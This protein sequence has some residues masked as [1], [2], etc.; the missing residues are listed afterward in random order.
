MKVHRLLFSSTLKSPMIDTFIYSLMDR[1]EHTITLILVKQT[2]L[3]GS[4]FS[5]QGL[6]ADGEPMAFPLVEYIV[7]FRDQVTNKSCGSAS[8]SNSSLC[9]QGTCSL[10]YNTRILCPNS[11]MIL[12]TVISMSKLGDMNASNSTLV[13]ISKWLW[14]P[15]LWL[16]GIK[17][18]LD[19]SDAAILFSVVVS[20]L[21]GIILLISVVIT[22]VLIIMK[23][24]REFAFPK[25]NQA[26]WVLLLI[27]LT[28]IIIYGCL[29]CTIRLIERNMPSESQDA[30]T[31]LTEVC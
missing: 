1:W 25:V 19:N 12:V 17:P 16:L 13:T 8:I 24:R 10:Q 14:Y 29:N 26:R 31:E 9:P 3:T 7:T 21:G 22:I 15:Y 5:S 28:N 4:F 30:F 11:V 23:R 18:A 27:I 20:A 2:L 6:L